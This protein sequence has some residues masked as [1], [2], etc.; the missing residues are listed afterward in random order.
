MARRRSCGNCIGYCNMLHGRDYRCGLGFEIEE[1]FDRIS[2]GMAI[3]IHPYQDA[4]TVIPKPRTKEEF[5][6][7]AADRGIE[8]DIQD[9]YLPSEIEYY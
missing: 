8:W 6:R 1:T 3:G 9:V 4:C 5:V 7:A 2:K